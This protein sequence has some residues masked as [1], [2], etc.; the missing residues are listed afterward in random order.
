ML[1][2]FWRIFPGIFLEDFSGHFSHKNEEKKT[3]EKIRE[4]SGGSKIKIREKSVLPKAGPNY[5]CCL[6]GVSLVG[7]FALATEALCFALC[8][9]GMCVCVHKRTLSK[10]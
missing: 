5:N 4:K 2:K 7:A 3:G 1:Y 9:V 8:L 10:L 6:G